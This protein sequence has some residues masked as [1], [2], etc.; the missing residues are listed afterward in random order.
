MQRRDALSVAAV[1]LFCVGAFTAI[2]S[3]VSG[4]SS[5]LPAIVSLVTCATLAGLAIW[6]VQARDDAITR[7]DVIEGQMAR[8]EDDVA[9]LTR[10]L[11]DLRTSDPV[12]GVLNRRTFLRRLAETIRRDQRLG[13]PLAVAIVELDSF[14]Q[15][16]DRFGRIGGDEA[17]RKAAAALRTATRGTDFVGRIGGSEFG[18]VLA[19]CEDPRRVVER[20]F[21]TLRA[22]SVGGAPPLPLRAW[23]GV[24]SATEV[25]PGLELADFVQLAEQALR[26]ARGTAWRY[27]A[28]K[29]V[30]RPA[31]TPVPGVPVSS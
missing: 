10:E 27:E 23:A 29:A 9:S 8:L 15:I 25:A 24:V 18:M 13:K 14:L 28:V 26:S 12:T 2:A 1:G 17:L 30:P 7:A 5:I 22:K 11:E 20:F 21:E 16:N 6:L 4:A 31:A 19:E 3:P